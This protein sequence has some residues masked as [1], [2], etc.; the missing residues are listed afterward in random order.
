MINLILFRKSMN[1]KKK[2]KKE[3][4][5]QQKI[6]EIRRKEEE[7]RRKKQA[8]EAERKRREDEVRKQ[9]EMERQME[10]KRKK[11]EAQRLKKL[12]AKGGT[13]LPQ[14]EAVT[15]PLNPAASNSIMS[16]ASAA[17]KLAEAKE[18]LAFAKDPEAALEELRAKHMRELQELQLMHQ[19]QLEEEAR[20][21]KL[22]QPGNGNKGHQPSSKS[23]AA[24]VAGKSVKR[25]E[26]LQSK[27]GTQIKIT[28]TPSGGVEFTTVPANASSQSGG[29][30][31]PQPS[32]GRPVIQQPP[33]PARP[34]VPS[35]TGAPMVTIRRIETPNA[36]EPMVTIS[37]AK[38]GNSGAANNK[39]VKEDKLLY[40]L[41][42]GQA[43]R[44]PDAP[45]DLLPNAKLV[46]GANL[47]KKQKKKLK[48]KQN[49]M[50]NQMIQQPQHSQSFPMM[51]GSMP[52]FT[53]MPFGTSAHMKPRPPPQS[54]APSK[55][56]QPL[57][58]DSNGK[59]DLDRLQLPPGISITRMS[60]P[61]PER[62]YFPASA[63]EYGSDRDQSVLPL[64]GTISS[65]PQT[66]SGPGGMDYS[67]MEGL[68]PGLNGPNV[69]VVDTSSLK[70]KEE[71]EREVSCNSKYSAP[72]INSPFYV[73]DDHFFFS[74]KREKG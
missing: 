46:E 45:S 33:E 41:V 2:A 48:Q 51:G 19:R 11:K 66:Q 5:K 14:D 69:I 47:S 16:T 1:E 70:T 55:P 49:Q 60:G 10:K 40:T 28:R 67:A 59:V 52:N 12:A 38:N 25:S 50:Q 29:V 20:R 42:N 21:L 39:Q 17:S 44:T 36:A 27:P 6:E 8:E 34:S 37:M 57:P 73:F 26:A 72:N 22:K 61:T 18:A 9:A 43:M 32:F 24:T 3:R 4:Q 13:V 23:E 53:P 64:P 54:T 35:K 56:R 30:S 15:P 31:Q 63:D 65:Q 74:G 68:P 58:L 71:E 7:E 62:K